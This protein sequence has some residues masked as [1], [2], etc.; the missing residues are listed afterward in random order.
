ML[1]HHP[2]IV[3]LH[4]SILVKGRSYLPA[5]KEVNVE[6]DPLRKWKF[7]ADYRS[8]SVGLNFPPLVTWGGNVKVTPL[9]IYEGV[10]TDG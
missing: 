8:T 6:Y 4:L 7:S 3:C 5:F 2:L 1:S 9:E 10:N